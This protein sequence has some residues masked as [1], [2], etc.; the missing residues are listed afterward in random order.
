MFYKNS[1]LFLAFLWV[2]D[3]VCNQKFTLPKSANLIFYVLGRFDVMQIIIVCVFYYFFYKLGSSVGL[4]IMAALIVL[5][6][7]ARLM[8]DLI[9]FF[10]SKMGLKKFFVFSKSTINHTISTILVITLLVALISLISVVILLLVIDIQQMVTTLN[11]ISKST[12]TLLEDKTGIDFFDQ[13]MMSKK[14]EELIF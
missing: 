11:G 10:L 4:V 13:D 9:R 7:L 5:D 3:V 1:Y 6:L 2:Y 14:Y 12:I 8:M